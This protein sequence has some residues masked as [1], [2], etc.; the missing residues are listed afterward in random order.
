MHRDAV[1]Q[2]TFDRG[3]TSTIHLQVAVVLDV[4]MWPDQL[5]GL[6]FFLL[7]TTAQQPVL[8]QKGLAGVQLRADN[9]RSDPAVWLAF[10]GERDLGLWLQ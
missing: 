8:A 4:V 2:T 5:P 1:A 6:W 7:N 3:P 10:A 9:C